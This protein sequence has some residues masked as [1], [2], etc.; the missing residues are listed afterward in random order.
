VDESNA[1]CTKQDLF[2]FFVSPLCIWLHVSI[3]RWRI[4]S[5]LIHHFIHRPFQFINLSSHVVNSTY[6]TITQLVETML[7]EL[8]AHVCMRYGEGEKMMKCVSDKIVNTFEWANDELQ[9]VQLSGKASLHLNNWT[10][11]QR[12][13]TSTCK[14]M[15]RY[16]RE[17]HEI[18][19]VRVIILWNEKK[20]H[21]K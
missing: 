14:T 2:S 11:K 6:Y 3:R 16:C 10:W 18:N 20:H 5:N 1:Y 15:P 4:N 17:A 13:Y 21:I 7:L 8:D 9:S 12:S 19:L